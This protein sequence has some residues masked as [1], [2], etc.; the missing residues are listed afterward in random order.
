MI[1]ENAAVSDNDNSNQDQIESMS[2]L[3][4][5]EEAENHFLEYVYILIKKFLFK[6][7][8]KF[9]L[10]VKEIAKRFLQLNLSL[11]EDSKQAKYTN[12]PNELVSY[13]AEKYRELL[14]GAFKYEND[15]DSEN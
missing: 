10:R 9:N 14:R 15:S 1:K 2:H 13:K 8:S 12:N 11:S 3:L 4:V 7:N 5:T 6:S